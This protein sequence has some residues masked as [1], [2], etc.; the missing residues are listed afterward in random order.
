MPR[1]TEHT[2]LAQLGLFQ[3]DNAVRWP[4]AMEERESWMPTLVTYPDVSGR[5]GHPLDWR[6]DRPVS[7]PD[8]D[9]VALR[10]HFPAG[11]SDPGLCEPD[12]QYYLAIGVANLG[13]R[14]FRGSTI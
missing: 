13:D 11:H 6:P 1:A 10:N 4:F 12:L 3:K 14:G 9:A 8:R 2:A 5:I 7:C